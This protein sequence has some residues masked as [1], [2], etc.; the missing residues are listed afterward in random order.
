MIGAAGMI[1]N[2]EELFAALEKLTVHEIEGVLQRLT[3]EER[4]EVDQGSR[5]RLRKVMSTLC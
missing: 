3:E 2:R 5:V 4:L 1:G